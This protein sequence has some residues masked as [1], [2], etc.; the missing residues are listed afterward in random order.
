MF[1]ISI[2]EINGLKKE[3]NRLSNIYLKVTMEKNWHSQMFNFLNLK[4]LSPGQFLGSFNSPRYH[5]ILKL[6]EIKFVWLFYYFNF[7]RN[8]DILTA[9]SPCILLS[10]NTNFNKNETE[11][12]TENCTHS[13]R[14]TNFVLKLI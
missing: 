1:F 10:K 13:F 14:E 2:K 3:I 7:E 11:L 6:L 9:K 5:W 12:K 4:N 8:Y